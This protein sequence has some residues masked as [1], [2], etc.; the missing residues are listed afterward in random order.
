MLKNSASQDLSY[1]NVVK[2]LVNLIKDFNSGI[3]Q[4]IVTLTTLVFP[5]SL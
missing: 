2:E 5:D 1:V 3:N 4:P